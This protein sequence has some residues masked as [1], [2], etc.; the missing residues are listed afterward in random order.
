MT[1]AND[2]AAE[3]A[4]TPSPR[5]RANNDIAGQLCTIER[6]LSKTGESDLPR[7]AGPSRHDS[8]AQ[9]AVGSVPIHPFGLLFTSPRDCHFRE[10]VGSRQADSPR[11]QWLV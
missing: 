10:H 2:R 9:L 7:R 5:P 4:R 11:K 1:S 8:P 6:S 3:G